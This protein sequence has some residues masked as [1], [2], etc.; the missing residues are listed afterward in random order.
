M[1]STPRVKAA[2]SALTDELRHALRGLRAQ[3]GFTAVPAL[4]LALAIGANTAVF[5]VVNGVLL[6]PLPFANSD[7]LMVA[8]YWPAYVKGW[9][10][11]PAMLGRDF[12]TFERLN[13]SFE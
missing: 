13:H 9:L 4:T 2:L 5:T 6:R 7:R 3:P 10:G 11:A 1:L 12:V 8:S